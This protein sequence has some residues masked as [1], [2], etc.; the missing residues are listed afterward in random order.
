MGIEKR[1]ILAGRQRGIEELKKRYMLDAEKPKEVDLSGYV[2]EDIFPLSVKRGGSGCSILTKGN[3]LVGNGTEPIEEKTPTEVL[4]EINAA[5]KPMLIWSNASETSNFEAQTI[6]LSDAS[7]DLIAIRFRWSTTDDGGGA[8][9]V[10]IKGAGQNGASTYQ[11]NRILRYVSY[12]EDGS[13]TF[14]GGYYNDSGINNKYCIPT[15]IWGI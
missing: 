9:L 10:C 14:T 11:S 1:D 15:Q 6:T 4:E 13:V 7:F 2:K 12:N 3:F 5:K 8:P